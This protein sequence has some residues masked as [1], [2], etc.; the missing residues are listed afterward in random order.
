MKRLISTGILICLMVS[1]L[2]GCSTG[3]RVSSAGSD[4]LIRVAVSIVPQEYL[5]NRIGGER[6]QVQVMIPPGSD[7]HTFEPNPGQIKKLADTDIYFRVGTLDF[8]EAWMDRLASAN[9]DMQVVDTSAMIDLV[10]NDPHVWLSPRLF[11]IQAQIIYQALSQLD[12]PNQAFYQ[13]NLQGLISDLD[14]LDQEIR[15]DLKDVKTS[16]FLVYHPAWSYF[17]AEYGLEEKA[18][19]TEG[20][21]PTAREMADLINWAKEVGIKTVFASPQHSSRSAEALARELGGEVVLLD[22]LAGDYL[23]NM[24]LTSSTLKRVLNS[25]GQ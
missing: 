12:K 18:V 25:Q 10:N 16:C 4:E 7:P 11:K 6:V 19:E 2:A 3:E 24:Q 22:P 14:R 17:A 9:Q 13:Q 5:V 8:E 23:Q 21:E 20:K 15:A 1:L